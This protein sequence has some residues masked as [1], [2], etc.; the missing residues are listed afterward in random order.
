MGPIA[1][2]GIGSTALEAGGKILET[3]AYRRY[4]TLFEGQEFLARRERLGIWRGTFDPPEAWRKRRK[5]RPR[6]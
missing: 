5:S 3:I 6:P 4:S 1:T 2:I